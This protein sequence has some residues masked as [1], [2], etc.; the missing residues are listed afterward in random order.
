MML[1]RMYLKQAVMSMKLYLRIPAA[2]FWIFGFPIVMLLGLGTVFGSHGAQAEKL[3]WAETSPPSPRDR[4]LEAA[5]QALGLQIEVLTPA[6]ADARWAAGKLPALL[7]SPGGEYMLRLN[8]YL[9]AQSRQIESLVQ[10][11]FLAGQARARGI[12]D[13]TRM[14]VV[15]ETPGGHRDGPYAAFLLPG[16]LGLNVLTMGVFYTGISDVTMREKGGYK[17]LATTPL[18]RHI[19]LLAQLTVRLLVVLVS[20]AALMLVGALVFGIHNQGAYLSVFVLLI[21]GS[22][23]FI[24]MGYLL[25]SFA[26]TVEVYSGIANFAFLTLML[27]S[28]VYFSIDAAP[29]WLQ[30]AA[31]LLPLAPLLTALRAVFNDG[32]ALGAQA[33]VLAIVGVWTLLLLIAAT[34]RFR[35]I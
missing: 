17:R 20:A 24:C 21:V 32:A 10:Q 5:C 7:T 8:G 12:T 16:L 33:S 26:S 30:R 11:A 1:W 23:C 25:A 15:M 27:M 9:G 2:L 35:W 13:L 14:P 31:D 29:V 34:R 6:D 3:V 4:D 19:W 28:G 18:P 22:A